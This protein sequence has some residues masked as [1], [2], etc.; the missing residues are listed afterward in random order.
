MRRKG[1]KEVYLEEAARLINRAFTSCM[2]DRY[3]HI[4]RIWLIQSAPLES[5]RKWGTYFF[6]S[7]LVK[8]YF[9]LNKPALSANVQRAVN[10]NDLPAITEFPR[11]HIVT[12]KYYY[13]VYAFGK[14]DYETVMPD[15]TDTDERLKES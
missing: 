3:P 1:E 14:E 11:S 10:V 4:E 12:W 8:T 7:M 9:R 15:Y 5:S 13:G 2:T 6:A